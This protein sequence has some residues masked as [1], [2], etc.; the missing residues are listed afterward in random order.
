MNELHN[1]HVC[2]PHEVVTSRAYLHT[3]AKV[4]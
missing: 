1:L 3:Q 4:Q 2:T